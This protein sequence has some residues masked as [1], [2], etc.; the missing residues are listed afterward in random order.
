M[1]AG[2]GIGAAGFLLLL[3]TRT[4]TAAAKAT[5]TPRMAKP[6]SAEVPG[7]CPTSKVVVRTIG[8][9]LGVTQLPDSLH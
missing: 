6:I 1:Y 2:G 3:I 5:M 4:T 8:L 7:F 9:K